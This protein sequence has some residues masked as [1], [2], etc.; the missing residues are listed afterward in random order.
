MAWTTF[1]TLGQGPAT[2]DMLDGNF[3]ILTVR[4]PV[5]CTVGGSTN[6]LVLTPTSGLAPLNTFQFGMQFSG[7]AVASNT[8][9]TTASVTGLAG[10]FPIY[11]DIST[12]STVLTGGEIVA[13]TL[14]T[15]FFDPAL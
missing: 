12:G 4:A 6:A 13:G 2:P 1:A 8:G 3:N 5:D 9:G 14:F 15:I 7:I 11:K 10:S